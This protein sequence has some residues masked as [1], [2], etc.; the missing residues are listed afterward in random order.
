MGVEEEVARPPLEVVATAAGV[1]EEDG[2]RMM[3]PNSSRGLGLGPGFPRG[4]GGRAPMSDR[5]G[6][7]AWVWDQAITKSDHRK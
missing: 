5:L 7:E 3:L 2:V 6:F 4:L 1:A